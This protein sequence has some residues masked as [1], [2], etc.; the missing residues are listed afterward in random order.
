MD[1]SIGLAAPGEYTATRLCP[2]KVALFLAVGTLVL[3]V[4]TLVSLLSGAKIIVALELPAAALGGWG[5]VRLARRR[6]NLT[7]LPV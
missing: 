1:G 6:G 2:V 7:D 5:A 4:L 3:F